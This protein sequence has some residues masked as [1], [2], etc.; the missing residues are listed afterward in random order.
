MGKE[1]AS[2]TK[3]ELIIMAGLLIVVGFCF[4]FA[5]GQETLEHTPARPTNCTTIADH[6][7]ARK[8]CI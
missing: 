5:I 6:D 8:V 4:G 3:L 7:E 1:V 2:F